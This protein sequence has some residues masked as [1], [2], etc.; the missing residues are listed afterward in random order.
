MPSPELE[1]ILSPRER[2]EA[3]IDS[4]LRVA[5][6]DDRHDYTKS[7][8]RGSI[9]FETIIL[10]DFTTRIIVT[11]ESELQAYIEDS[12]EVFA[13]TES[14]VVMAQDTSMESVTFAGAAWRPWD[15]ILPPRI[16][17]IDGHI[18]TPEDDTIVRELP[19]WLAYKGDRSFAALNEIS[20]PPDP[21]RHLYAQQAA[22][23]IGRSLLA[24]EIQNLLR[25]G[26]QAAY[27]EAFDDISSQL[28]QGP[29]EDG[30]TREGS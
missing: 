9:I 16:F 15:K 21:F 14:Y 22:L 23:Y 25:I 4:L 27:K 18:L 19:E 28:I 13:S 2:L 3:T 17:D 5:E 30:V 8:I 11:R 1:G 29:G 10:S 20:E 6:I 7:V 12:P 26:S 24:K